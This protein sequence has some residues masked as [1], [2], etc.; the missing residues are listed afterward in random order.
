[1]SGA[2]IFDGQHS[3]TAASWVFRAVLDDI[4]HMV[5]L[6]ELPGLLRA[7]ASAREQGVDYLDLSELSLD[8]LNTLIK[9]FQN[10]YED[11]ERRGPSDFKSPEFFDGYM[12]RFRDLLQIA[13]Q[14]IRPV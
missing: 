5:N 2:I 6:N 12:D 7:L 14:A 1:M 4:E 11:R 3:W 9:I 13:A 10:A 8:D